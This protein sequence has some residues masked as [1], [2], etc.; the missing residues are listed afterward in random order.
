VEKTLGEEPQRALSPLVN[1]V[2]R[3]LYSPHTLTQTDEDTAQ[4]ALL[5]LRAVI[6]RHKKKV[7]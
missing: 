4:T 5:A 1:L 6:K 3:A 2:E 7:G